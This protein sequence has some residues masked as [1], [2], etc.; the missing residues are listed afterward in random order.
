MTELNN[1][2]KVILIGGSSHTGKSTTAR[3]L[4]KIIGWRCLSTDSL[5]RHPGRPWRDNPNDIPKH[6]V[7]HYST[8]AVN[9]LFA[10]VL[11]HYWNVWQKVEEI[12][13]LQVNDPA[14]GCLIIEGSAIWP[15]FIVSHHPVS[16]KA[17]WLT[18]DQAL[19]KKRIYRASSYDRVS[20]KERFLIDKFLQ[21]TVF[22]NEKMMPILNQ[23]HLANIEV[24]DSISPDEIAETCLNL[25]FA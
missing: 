4:A 22:F 8:L 3:S 9:E 11:K 5:A 17:I 12:I 16:T 23:H 1:N 6:V 7:E 25:L 13:S 18:A 10:D 24:N 19:F 2:V 14:N 20:I 21:R 15:E